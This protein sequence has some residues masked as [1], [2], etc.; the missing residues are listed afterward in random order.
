M[1]PYLEAEPRAPDPETES[2]VVVEAHELPPRSWPLGWD[3][4]GVDVR[5]YRVVEETSDLYV[6]TIFK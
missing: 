5:P 1:T 6:P 4:S 2:Q 3:S